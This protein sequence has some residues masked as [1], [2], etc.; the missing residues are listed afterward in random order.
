MK[1]KRLKYLLLLNFLSCGVSEEYFFSKEW[2]TVYNISAYGRPP[3]SYIKEMDINL[4]AWSVYHGGYNEKEHNYVKEIHAQGVIVASNFPTMQASLSVVGKAEGLEDFACETLQGERAKA[5]WIQPDPPYLPCHNNPAWQSFMEERIKEH[6][7]G[8]A[9]AIHFDEI[10]GIGGHLYIA[11]FCKYCMSEFKKHLDENY[12][13]SELKEIFGI[14][15]LSTFN[16]REYLISQGVRS[17]GSS[18]NERLRREFVRFQFLSRKKQMR[19]LMDV[20]REFARREIVFGGNA[21][22]YSP[23]KHPFME[24]LD[25]T[26]SENY[27]EFPPHAKYAGTYLLAKAISPGKPVITFPTIIDLK[28]LSLQGKDWK[29]ISFRIAESASLSTSFLIPYNAYVFGGGT[30]TVSGFATLPPE[31]GKPVTSF[32]RKNRDFLLGEP[33][34]DVG[35]FYDFSCAF[36]DYEKYGYLYPYLPLGEVHTGYLGL[37]LLLQ[38]LHIPFRVVYEGDGKLI[39]TNFKNPE[40]PPI[41]ILLIPYSP[42]DRFDPAGIVKKLEERNVKVVFLPDSYKYWYGGGKSLRDDVERILRENLEREMIRTDAPSFISVIPMMRKDDFIVHFL[43]YNY[44]WSLH[45]FLPSAPF[46]IFLCG[47]FKSGN[48]PIFS[49]EGNSSVYFEE[50]DGCIDGFI[51]SF[52]TWAFLKLPFNQ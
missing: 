28:N 26:V 43:N 38:E 18:P 1:A 45:D 31:A 47:N 46:H 37:T 19:K 29:V 11:G 35:V 20:A 9:D 12:T 21:F 15:E 13:P 23:N 22:F 48:Y 33:A 42:C 50:K 39:S 51:P 10:E 36:E 41:K 3:V 25:F 52:F 34:G 5:L 30:S 14:T 17:L 2:L 8:D 27:V 16:Y 4:L 49:P 40:I 7:L 24:D 32:I 6:I 44:S